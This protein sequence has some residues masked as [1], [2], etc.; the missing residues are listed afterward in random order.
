M[1][2][3]QTGRD[4]VAHHTRALA[5]WKRLLEATIAQDDADAQ[6]EAAY[7]AKRIDGHQA[8]L[9]RAFGEWVAS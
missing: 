3:M 1:H 5:D 9:V 4:G 8:R 7:I 2:T 6:A